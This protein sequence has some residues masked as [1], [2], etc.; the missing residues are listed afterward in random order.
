VSLDIRIAGRYYFGTILGLTDQA[1]ET[2]IADSQV[3]DDFKRNQQLFMMDFK[4]PLEQC[5]SVIGIKLHGAGEFR[6]AQQIALNGPLV[7][8]DARA[9]WAK[10]RN[11]EIESASVEADTTDSPSELIVD[12]P[13]K[14]A[15]DRV[16]A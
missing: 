15:S 7:A 8:P 1:G 13:I 3:Q 9:L 6:S 11:S 12:V 4:V 5:D 2:E 16:P 14:P 10:A